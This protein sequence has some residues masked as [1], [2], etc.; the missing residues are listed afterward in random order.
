[1]HKKKIKCATDRFNGLLLSADYQISVVRE[2]SLN[3]ITVDVTREKI[4]AGNAPMNVTVIIGLFFVFSGNHQ[5]LIDKFDV[6]LVGLEI[7]QRKSHLWINNTN[8]TT[9]R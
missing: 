2:S 6:D 3:F 8:T 7:S 9:S 4:P 1:M 5:R